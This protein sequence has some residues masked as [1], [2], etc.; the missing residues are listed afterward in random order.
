MGAY[1]AKRKLRAW[2]KKDIAELKAHSKAR[3]PVSKISK[4]MKR[5]VGALRQKAGAV[6]IRLGHRR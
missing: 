3:T 1:M 5:T 4:V 2:T 6:G